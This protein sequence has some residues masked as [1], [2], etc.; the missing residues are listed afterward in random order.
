[1]LLFLGC[2][3][4][5]QPIESPV[6]GGSFFFQLNEV[7]W[8]G[9]LRCCCCEG[10]V[11]GQPDQWMN[12]WAL[13]SAAAY[14]CTMK[15]EK[16]NGWATSNWVGRRNHSVWRRRRRRSSRPIPRGI[17][18]MENAGVTKEDGRVQAPQTTRFRLLHRA[19][20]CFPDHCYQKK[21]LHRIRGHQSFSMTS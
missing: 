7:S 17:G 18:G 6:T 8:C 21:S 19:T 13:A 9:L 16:M 4:S 1:M 5:T 2:S 11:D 12:E 10:R 15:W 3:S 20:R 14:Y